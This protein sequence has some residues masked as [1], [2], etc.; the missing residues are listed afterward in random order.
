[1]LRKQWNLKRMLAAALTGVLIVSA[2]PVSAA[3][4]E[5]QST[6][7]WNF[8]DAAFYSLKKIS[9]TTTVDGLTLHAT[10]KK[11]MK[12]V[13][14]TTKV[15]NDAYNYCVKLAGSGT[16]EYRS[17]SFAL[18]GDTEIKVVA[19]ASSKGRNLV[20]TD[21]AGN[22]L[23]DAVTVGTSSAEY[24]F[25]YEG[26][27]E[28]VYL[29]ST[30][31]GVDLYDVEI[32][33]EENTEEGNTEESTEASTEEGTEESTEE[34]TEEG[35]E[36]ST[37]ESTEEG[38]EESTEESTEEGT[39]EGSTEE[40]TELSSYQI[41]GFAKGDSVTGGGVAATTDASYY[42][43][44]TAEDLAKALT[45]KKVKVIEIMNDLDLGWNEIGSAVQSYACMN[46]NA[47]ALMHPELIESGVTQIKVAKKTDMTIFSA[48]GA[49]IRHAGFV[50]RNCSN[51]IVRNLE[52][53]ELWEWDESTK[54]NYD[55]NDWDYITMEG[56]AGFWVD[57]C[58]FHQAYDGCC[59]SKKGTTGLSVTYCNFL[60][61]DY[62]SK[63]VQEQFDYLE[64]LYQ[65]GSSAVPMYTYIRDLGV[66]QETIQKVS[67]YQK[68]CC[69][70]G[71]TELESSNNN[72]EIYLANNTFTGAR[73][74]M[75][76][77]RG[78]VAVEI[79][80]I[81]DSSATYEA[82]Q[83]IS[84]SIR[85]KVKA[86]GYHLS[87]TSQCLLSTEGGHLYASGCAILGIT[88]PLKNNQKSASK[89]AYTG[90]ILAENCYYSCGSTTFYGSSAEKNSPLA[91]SG[92]TALDWDGVDLDFTYD[93]V[94]VYDLMK[95]LPG[96]TGAGILNLTQ[97]Q[98]MSVT[99]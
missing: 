42:Q 12:V 59:D 31:D 26:S 46:Q 24:T 81:F 76:R 49:K 25:D 66:S 71:A 94:S 50:F 69:L 87:N 48:N 55:R 78:G 58:T 23:D 98:W 60:S 99:Y 97:A 86:K 74:R 79:N 18:N 57:H 44:Y 83:L 61:G 90:Y 95:T 88:S 10:S 9:A 64:N 21:A 40:T 22:L 4:A 19:K 96:T 63:F 35:T 68:K 1:M 52:F 16:A 77:L 15:G 51:V 73:D 5:N 92:A 43:V 80:N 70:I 39:E 2:Q 3:A 67:S 29:Y 38:T 65:A 89:S 36:E 91:P 34:S 54:G 27:G 7:N 53:D 84:S 11:S 17:V 41:A 56:C 14:S 20:L 6:K 62:T 93:E 72:L 85:N 75:V 47:T 33:A 13:K 45:S 82:D 28:T 30:V 32:T 37:E 8:S